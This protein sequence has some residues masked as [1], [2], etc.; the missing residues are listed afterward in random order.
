VCSILPPDFLCY[1]I[2]SL[3]FIYGGDLGFLLFCFLGFVLTTVMSY[4]V[5]PTLLFLSPWFMGF[6]PLFF[7][8]PK[9]VVIRP[10]SFSFA[11]RRV[12]CPPPA[13]FGNIH[14]QG[15]CQRR[16]LT[17]RPTDSKNEAASLYINPS[18]P[19]SRACCSYSFLS[20]YTP[21]MFSLSNLLLGLV[22]NFQVFLL[23]HVCLFPTGRWS[24]FLLRSPLS[25][26]PHHFLPPLS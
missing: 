25:R 17:E 2:S 23:G 13:G 16:P 24:I 12:Y 5:L 22:G 7:A 4:G 6:P 15:S 19:C 20:V 21:W 14:F 11:P 9:T 8:S 18:A 3:F 1:L 10:P 26:G